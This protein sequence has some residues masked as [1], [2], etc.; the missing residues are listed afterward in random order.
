MKAVSALDELA[1]GMADPSKTREAAA[2]ILARAYIDKQRAIDEAD[3]TNDY[4]A[5]RNLT[6]AQGANDQYR[7]LYSDKRYDDERLALEKLL[8]TSLQFDQN[9][10]PLK[11]AEPLVNYFI[12]KGSNPRITPQT[13][14]QMVGADVA[15]Y[16]QAP[17]R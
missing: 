3:F 5:G 7:R 14:N 11:N 16:F 15:R 13:I 10:M 9:G 1:K 12:G 4:K 17:T 6:V 2:S 8:T